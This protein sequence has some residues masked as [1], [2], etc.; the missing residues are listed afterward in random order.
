MIGGSGWPTAL[1]QPNTA[2]KTVPKRLFAFW[3][4]ELRWQQQPTALTPARPAV[5]A[6]ESKTTTADSYS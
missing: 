4:G 5:L 1:P 3:R 6:P 2:R